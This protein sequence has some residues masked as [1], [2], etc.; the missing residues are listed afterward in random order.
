MICVILRSMCQSNGSEQRQAFVRGQIAKGF[1]V[2]P[3]P[4]ILSFSFSRHV[5]IGSM[6]HKG[7]VPF[8]FS[9]AARQEDGAGPIRHLMTTT[10]QHFFLSFRNVPYFLSCGVI[11]GF[12]TLGTTRVKH[13]SLASVSCATSGEPS[14]HCVRFYEVGASGLLEGMPAL[15][16]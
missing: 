15:Q 10:M 3:A 2:R 7:N 13:R 4:V 5:P 14:E 16:K 11:S 12:Q 8:F 9:S 1:F 6:C